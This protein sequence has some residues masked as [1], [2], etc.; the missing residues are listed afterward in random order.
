[1]IQ[2]SFVAIRGS[3]CLPAYPSSVFISAD[4][5]F[6]KAAAALVAAKNM[7][8]NNDVEVAYAA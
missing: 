7:V 4:N 5:T 8:A 2:I 1:M 6:V 3:R